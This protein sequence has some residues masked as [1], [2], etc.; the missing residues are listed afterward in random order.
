MNCRKCDHRYWE[1]AGDGTVIIWR[2]EVTEQIL[3][4]GEP[5]MCPSFEREEADDD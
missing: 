1:Y 5:C 2:C 3:K 4:G